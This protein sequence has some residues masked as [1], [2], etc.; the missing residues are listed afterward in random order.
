MGDHVVSLGDNEASWGIIVGS[1]RIIQNHAGS[2]RIL[3]DYQVSIRIREVLD[4][5]SNSVDY[6]LVVEKWTVDSEIVEP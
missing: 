4:N 1:C 2:S 5:F 3:Q 6:V